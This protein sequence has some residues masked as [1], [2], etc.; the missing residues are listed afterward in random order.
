MPQP[1]AASAS[2]T[3]AAIDT[4]SPRNG[5]V[6]DGVIAAITGGLAPQAATVTSSVFAGLMRP[7]ASLTTRRTVYVPCMSGWNHGTD[8]SVAL[9]CALLPVGALSRVQA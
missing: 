6:V 5:A 1:A 7:S 8:E 3:V 4:C 2:V 9:S